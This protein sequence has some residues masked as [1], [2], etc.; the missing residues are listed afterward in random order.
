MVLGTYRDTELSRH[1]PLFETL[2]ELA[3]SPSFQ[4]IEL[5]GL[6][7]RETEEFMAAAERRRR[8]AP[9]SSVRSTRAPKAIRCFSRK[10]CA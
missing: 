8:R 7:S 2:A 10:R 3:R 5:A 1:H 4:R 9:A 6:S